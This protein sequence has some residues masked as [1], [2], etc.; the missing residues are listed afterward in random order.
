[1]KDDELSKNIIWTLLWPLISSQNNLFTDYFYAKNV[2]WP[3]KLLISLSSS[4]YFWRNPLLTIHFIGAVV[5][6]QHR[7][8]WSKELDGFCQSERNGCSLKNAQHKHRHAIIVTF[9]I[10]RVI[11][12]TLKMLGASSFNL[13]DSGTF[14]AV[15]AHESAP[16]EETP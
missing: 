14:R 2:S 3:L 16:Q 7:T 10:K 8:E 11:L 9:S 13:K 6:P 5:F 15:V 12:G 1:M 4:V